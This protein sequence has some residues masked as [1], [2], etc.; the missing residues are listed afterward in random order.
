[1]VARPRDVRYTLRRIVMRVTQLFA[2][3]LSV[4]PERAALARAIG[5]VASA[6]DPYADVDLARTVK[7]LAIQ[8]TAE[9]ARIAVGKL[10]RDA[11]E[12]SDRDQRQAL[13]QAVPV[14][15]SSPNAEQVG[16]ILGQILDDLR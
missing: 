9:Q 3:E 11:M 13:I 10:L 15:G 6:N 7:T 12:T 8:P 14:F 2:P 4:E 5:A 1:M 16:P